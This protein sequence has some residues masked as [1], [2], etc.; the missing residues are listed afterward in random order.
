MN[1]IT[2]GAAARGSHTELQTSRLRAVVAVL[3]VSL[4]AF[5]TSVRAGGIAIVSQSAEPGSRT[6][7]AALQDP[8]V[9]DVVVLPALYNVRAEF[10]SYQGKPISLNR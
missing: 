9:Q 4:F 8:T 2:R 7:L 6:L 3:V 10:E 5:S 1:S